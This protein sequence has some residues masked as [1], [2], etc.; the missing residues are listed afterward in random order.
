[1]RNALESRTLR[2]NDTGL[3]QAYLREYARFHAPASARYEE[4]KR[5]FEDE[6]LDAWFEERK[7]KCNGAL[8]RA[9][10]KAGARPYEI[11]RFGTKGTSRYGLALSPDAVA[12]LEDIP[13]ASASL[14]SGTTPGKP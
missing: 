12:I 6:M 3:A 5:R 7:A 14:W 11:Q 9:L 13:L 8:R 10:G 4:A 1:M 2:W